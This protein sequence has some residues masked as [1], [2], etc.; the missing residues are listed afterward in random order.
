VDGAGGPLACRVSAANRHD[1]T[2]LLAVALAVPLRLVGGEDRL[3]R[4]WLG[5]Q[6]SDSEGHKAIPRWLGAESVLA[7]R[8]REHDSGLGQEWHMVEP[9]RAALHPNR[10]LK[11]RYEQRSDIHLAFLTLTCLKVCFYGLCPDKEV[12]VTF[13]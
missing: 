2:A 9:T 1:E 11:V 8:G 6:A 5:D 4:R 13:S 12:F 7:Q 3:P 10:R